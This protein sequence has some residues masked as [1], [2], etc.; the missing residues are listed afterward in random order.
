MQHGIPGPAIAP[1]AIATLWSRTNAR[2]SLAMPR[3]GSGVSPARDSGGDAPNERRRGLG[4]ELTL[5]G[6]TCAVGAP[7]A[8]QSLTT[9]PPDVQLVAVAPGE[10]LQV[11][12]SGRGPTVLLVP[13]LFGSA[14]AYRH[15]TEGLVSS[16]Y[17]ALVIEPLAL[18]GS[19][20]PRGA[21]YSLTAQSDR[22]A[23][24]LTLIGAEPAI[25][26]GH[27]VG[28]SMVLRLGYRHPELVRA[29]VLLDGG[30]GEAAATPGFRKALGLV[31]WVKWLGGKRIL[32][33]RV[34]K[35]LAAASAD[36]AWVTDEVIA[37]Y[38]ATATAQLDATLAAFRSMAESREPEALGPRLA[39]IGCPVR[40]V[41]GLAPHPGGIPL[42]QLQLLRERLPRFAIDSVPGAGHYLFEEQP[43]AVLA[44]IVSVRAELERAAAAIVGRPN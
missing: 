15:L 38:T 25:V 26:V 23:A 42:E 7:L 27:A 40:L 18:G 5:L 34:K 41:V 30:P 12:I 16:G 20:R 31:K 44:I 13:G 6:I 3:G 11:T 10:S 35:E 37:G 39:E 24:A 28:G 32:R 9:G 19:S 4:R 36:P 1:D 22:L 8:G 43:Q 33:G 2:P 21:D 17:R 29:I 14:F